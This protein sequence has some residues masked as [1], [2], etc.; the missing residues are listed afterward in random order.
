MIDDISSGF[1]IIQFKFYLISKHLCFTNEDINVQ[2]GD[3]GASFKV[4]RH[5]FNVLIKLLKGKALFLIYLKNSYIFISD[6]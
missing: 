3:P 5:Y 4:W 6:F 2:I 1:S